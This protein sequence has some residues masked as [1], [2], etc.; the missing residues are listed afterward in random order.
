[1][2]GR[3]KSVVNPPGS[4]RGPLDTVRA[5]RGLVQARVFS[6][7]VFRIHDAPPVRA[8]GTFMIRSRPNWI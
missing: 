7:R 3:P 4:L 6:Q 1:M 5:Q 2:V 8:L